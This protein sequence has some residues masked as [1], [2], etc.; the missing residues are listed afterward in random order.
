M[1]GNSGLCFSVTVYVVLYH[2]AKKVAHEIIRSNHT[3]LHFLRRTHCKYHQKYYV[4]KYCKLLWLQNVLKA[5]VC[6]S[7]L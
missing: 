4:S 7:S 5:S 2:I 3:F 1:D 6:L